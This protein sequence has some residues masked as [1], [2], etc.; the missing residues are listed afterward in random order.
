MLEGRCE[1]ERMGIKLI[2]SINDPVSA[3]LGVW[4]RD[5][6]SLKLIFGV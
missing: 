1:G 6:E 5:D 4:S 2:L 3:I